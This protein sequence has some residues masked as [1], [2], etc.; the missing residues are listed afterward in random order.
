MIEIY[1]KMDLKELLEKIQFYLASN[2]DSIY[3]KAKS[4]IGTGKI[5]NLGTLKEK[6][7]GQIET[8]LR[9]VVQN[10]IYHINNEYVDDPFIEPAI[11]AYKEKYIKYLEKAIE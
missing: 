10:I 11:E 7:K 3:E 1:E 9:I 4:L 5:H 6:L 8:Y 2:I